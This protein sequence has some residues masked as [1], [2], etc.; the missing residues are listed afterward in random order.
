MQNMVIVNYGRRI[1]SMDSAI[2]MTYGWC[3]FQ[4]PWV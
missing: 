4:W 1:R 2:L 3:H